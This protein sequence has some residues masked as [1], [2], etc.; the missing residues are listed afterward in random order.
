M[1]KKVQPH[2]R[3]FSISVKLST[4]F[5]EMYVW[6]FRLGNIKNLGFCGFPQYFQNS[7]Y[8]ASTAGHD[9]SLPNHFQLSIILPT[10]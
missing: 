5:R 3:H 2:I 8:I 1:L 4:R 6:E 10:V 9:I 7:A